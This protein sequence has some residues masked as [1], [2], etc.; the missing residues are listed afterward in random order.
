MSDYWDILQLKDGIKDYASFMGSAHY[1]AA[2]FE[3]M[4]EE[5]DPA[6]LTQVGNGISYITEDIT[7]GKYI[8]E[9]GY[10]KEMND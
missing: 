10:P 7:L 2:A 1:I 8:R 6:N 3:Q 4:F 9:V 5:K